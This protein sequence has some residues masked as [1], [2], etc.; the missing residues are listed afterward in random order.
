MRVQ[1]SLR[2][3][4]PLAIIALLAVSSA[5]AGMTHSWPA[6]GHT[7]DTVGMADGTLVGN[8][9]YT[10]GFIGQGFELDGNDSAI[11]FGT[12]VGVFGTS[13]FSIAFAIQAAPAQTVEDLIGKRDLCAASPFW[14]VRLGISGSIGFELYE[15][16]IN[17][18]TGAAV[19][20]RDGVFHTVVITRQGSVVSIYVDGKLTNRNDAGIVADPTNTAEMGVSNGACIDA[21]GTLEFVGVIDEIRLADTA[22]PYL[23]LGDFECGDG[24]LNGNVTA[25]DALAA[26]RA[27]VGSGECPDCVCDANNSGS[28]TASDALLILQYSVG[29]PLVLTCPDCEF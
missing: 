22:E 15:S 11:T 23:L 9:T 4:L 26:L 25:T 1:K 28:I 19:D 7:L 21:D 18:G 20:V 13:D 29:Q 6:E 10:A 8:V 3:A 12:E 14:N 2:R 27:A 24:A 16:T 5:R 17:T